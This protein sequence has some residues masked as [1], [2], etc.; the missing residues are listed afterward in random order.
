MVN[1]KTSYTTA[2]AA[3][4]GQ[5]M[6]DLTV[7]I[8]YDHRVNNQLE[9]IAANIIDDVMEESQHVFIQIQ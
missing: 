2:E 8:V 6:H 4:S 9:K 5:V 7:Y 1:Y 3:L